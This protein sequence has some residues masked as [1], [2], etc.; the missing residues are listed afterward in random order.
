MGRR[1]SAV[2]PEFRQA[3]GG[4]M[5]S[6][7]VAIAV[8]V[9]VI[10]SWSA[11]SRAD[12]RTITF[13]DRSPGQITTEYHDQG[14]DF[15]KSPD[16][17]VNGNSTIVS[18]PATARSAPNV[19]WIGCGVEIC[20]ARVWA[21]F[22]EPHSNVSVYAGTNNTGT[23]PATITAYDLS[24]TQI[25]SQTQTVGPTETTPL[26]VVST[27][28]NIWFVSVA[29]ADF[30]KYV[31]LDDLTFDDQP[32][33]TAPDFG[34][35]A[36]DGSVVSL[37]SGTTTPV[38]LT[39]RRRFGSSGPIS[40]SVAGL[41]SGVTADVIPNPATG[42]DGSV[43][44]LRLT[45]APDAPPATGVPVTVTGTPETPSAGTAPRSV[46]IP[47]NVGGSFS[48]FNLRLKGIEPTQGIQR[49]GFLIPSGSF[50]N[51]GEYRG[52]DLV[53]GGKTI[54]RV[55]AD[56]VGGPPQGVP[57]GVILSGTDADGHRLPGGPL[58]PIGGPAA[59]T[60]TPF[61]GVGPAERM[62]PAGAYTFVLPP[63][64]TR[65]RIK[66]RADLLPPPE[67]V[68]RGDPSYREC[69]SA[70]CRADNTYSIVEVNFYLVRSYTMYVLELITANTKAPIAPLEQV[71]SDVRAWAPFGAGQLKLIGPVFTVRDH[72][73]DLNAQVEKWWNDHGHPADGAMG[74]ETPGGGGAALDSSPTAIAGA[75]RPFTAIS[76]EF[77]HLLSREHASAACDGADPAKPPS[78]ENRYEPWP[79][80]EL[81][82]LQGIA[83]DRR[84]R[85]VQPTPYRIVAAGIP[86]AQAQAYDFMSYCAI[87]TQD[88][89]FGGEDRAWLSPQNWQ[90][91]VDAR[92][93]NAGSA[94]RPARTAAASP[95]FHVTA[96][97]SDAGARVDDVLRLK[98]APVAYGAPSAY[99][100]RSIDGSGQVLA[101]VP[102]AGSHVH[103]EGPLSGSDAGDHVAGDVPATRDVQAV[104]VLR[105]D[106]VIASRAR[107]VNPPRVR[108]LSIRRG[109][110][111]LVLRW[112]ASDRDGDAIEATVDYSGDDGDHWHGVAA[113][114]NKGAIRLPRALLS[115][116]RRARVRLRVSDGFNETAA[117]SPRFREAGHSPQVWIDSP[118]P[119]S[120]MPAD[121]TLFLAG[122]AVD[123]RFKPLGLKRLR[124]YDGRRLLGRGGQLAIT[125]ALAP[126]LRNIRL[127]ASDRARRTSASSVL[128]RVAAVAPRFLSLKVPGHLS[129]RATR[130]RLRV[131]ASL[132]ATLYA[133]RQRA[134]VGRRARRVTLRI[135]PG[136]SG[137]KVRLRLR[138]GRKISIRT[139]TVPRG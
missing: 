96:T 124:W 14:V 130:L 79:P 30:S 100:L 116:A 102:M 10:L 115:R 82:Y 21:D 106:S 3:Y 81:G 126:G 83:V 66:L 112:R 4:L 78:D 44:T 18:T 31:Y 5:A 134:S 105:G 8:A 93:V 68:F 53:E 139:V 69:A 41:P 94:A 109:G 118:S 29:A 113:A 25:D 77:G 86:D 42:G 108:I 135:H 85:Y 119:R 23:H 127:V 59:L 117:L 2:D 57:A 62:D 22:T 98:S 43:I 80:D 87:R 136:S 73:T 61:P 76:H 74:I 75:A 121:A 92:K 99:R 52:V 122:G 91:I 107:S 47:V 65:G 120:R 40:L 125:G 28:Q 95:Y 104:Q 137:L 103:V 32:V 55:Y 7:A 19:L 51:G 63:A 70:A 13:D 129:R 88:P 56:A 50:G 24:G 90:N 64:W 123:D 34:L 133:L 39:L 110:R 16:G 101:D 38:N 67:P 9:V 27:E 36:G 1:G 60:A 6:R 46:T 11:A 45:V 84:E 37:T 58:L 12:A 49:Q 48:G 97:A 138:A 26:T 132:P 17:G 20:P 89:F 111:G 35:I 114:G 54:V 15:G 131:R 71:F 128:V 33:S 72:D